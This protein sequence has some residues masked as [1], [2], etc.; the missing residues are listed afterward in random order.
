MPSSSFR[1]PAKNCSGVWKCRKAVRS[2]N[3]ANGTWKKSCTPAATRQRRS[4]AVA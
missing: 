1:P 3:Q 2:P 4:F